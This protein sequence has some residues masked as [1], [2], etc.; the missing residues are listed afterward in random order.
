MNFYKLEHDTRVSI[1]TS[2]TRMTPEHSTASQPTARLRTAFCTRATIV[3]LLFTV[4]GL[5]TLA[6]NGQY[7]PKSNPA[8]HVSIAIKMN[9][10]HSSM[11][12]AEEPLQ[13]VARFSPPQPVRA[14]RVRFE[15]PPAVAPVGVVVSMQH[16]SPPLTLA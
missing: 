12:L 10:V 6:K 13:P 15:E 7:Y 9:V 1:K 5:A 4:A 2:D 16:R 11:H 14:A 3:I 8:Q